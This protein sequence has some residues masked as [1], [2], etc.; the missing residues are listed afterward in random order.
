M[1]TSDLLLMQMQQQR[2]KK[3]FSLDIMSLLKGVNVKV[4]GVRN[5]KIS[6]ELNAIELN[7]ILVYLF[8]DMLTGMPIDLGSG[9][10]YVG[11][12]RYRDYLNNLPND[13]DAGTAF[14]IEFGM[15]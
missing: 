6:V 2:K 3:D 15:V 11:E 12:L 13:A 8:D 7:D 14:W 10:I 5:I 9:P 1:A 4:Y